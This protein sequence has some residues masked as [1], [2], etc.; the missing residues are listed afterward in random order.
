MVR[1]DDIKVPKVPE[2]ASLTSYLTLEQE[3]TILREGINNAIQC[4]TSGNSVHISDPRPAL[5]YLNKAL[6]EIK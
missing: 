1:K 5:K 6:E 4:L 3:N 2:D